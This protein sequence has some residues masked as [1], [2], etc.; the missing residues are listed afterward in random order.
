ME[1]QPAVEARQPTVVQARGYG[2]ARRLPG[3][4]DG[5][6]HPEN[7]RVEVSLLV[8]DGSD[9]AYEPPETPREQLEDA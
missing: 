4:D 6:N 7:R 5:A 3:F 1:L 9:D 2:A 8:G